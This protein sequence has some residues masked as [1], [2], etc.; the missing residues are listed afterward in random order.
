MPPCDVPVDVLIPTCRRPAALAVSL[1]GLAAQTVT[2]ARV[3]VSDGGAHPSSIDAD[4]VAAVARVLAVRGCPVEMVRH[5]RRG[6]AEHRQSL[7]D[8]ARAPRILF[9]DDDVLLLPTG[10]E[11]LCAAMDRARCGFV[12]YGPIGAGHADDHRPHEQV[13]EPWTGP[14][15]P[16]LVAPGTPEWRRHRLHGA[17]NL[18]HVARRLGLGDDDAVLYRVAWIGGCVLYDATALRD[19]GGFRFWPRLP[20]AHAGEDVVAQLRVLARAGGAGV[21][22]SRAHHLQ[23]AT[24]V[25]DR[26]VDAPHVVGVFDGVAATGDGG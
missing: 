14:V 24:T 5:P 1:A 25:A 26:T 7:L 17:A 21:L 9:L 11:R 16:E 18:L 10:L 19:A 6:P 3:V 20:A 8:R 12:G 13:L 15:V 4:E 22:P 23:L 2:P